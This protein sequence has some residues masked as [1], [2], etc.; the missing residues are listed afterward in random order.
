M[1]LEENKNIVRRYQEAYDTN[2]LDLLDEVVAPDL[3]STAPTYPGMPSGLELAKQAHKVTLAVFPDFKQA[4][5]EL[6]AEGDRVV[7][8]FRATGS[9]SGAPLMGMPP[10]GKKFDI[11][12]ISIFRIANGKI[13]EHWASEDQLGLMQQVGLLPS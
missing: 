7:M 6:I 2:N 8:R 10:S 5:I 11:V 1:S 13:A 4:I 3:R 12:G 9:H